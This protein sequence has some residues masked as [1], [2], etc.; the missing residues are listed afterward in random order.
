MKRMLALGAAAV[1]AVTVVLPV[2][3]ADPPVGPVYPF[4]PDQY[5]GTT[6]K[7]G[8]TLLL[9][10]HWGGCVPGL[11]TEFPLASIHQWYIDGV[12]LT[13]SGRWTRAIAV[14]WNPHPWAPLD[15]SACVSQVAARTTLYGYWTFW[16][17]PV[18][19][20]AP[21]DHVIRLVSTLTRPVLDGGDYNLDK[22][23]DMFTPANW[24]L[25]SAITV[26]VVP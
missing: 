12:P 25:D 24:T 16:Q 21:G 6:V 14:D 17:Y 8:Q 1:L 11:V 18:V 9:G 4:H 3:A 15:F 10:N 26:H 20:S 13:T 2:G 22:R 19:F 5:N 7:V 23:P